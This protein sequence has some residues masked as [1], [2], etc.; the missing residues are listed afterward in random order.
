MIYDRQCFGKSNVIQLGFTSTLMTQVILLNNCP[1][2]SWRRG[3][4]ED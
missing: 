1:S 2:D 4:I 3:E